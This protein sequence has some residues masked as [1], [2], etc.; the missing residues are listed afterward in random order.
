MDLVKAASRLQA[1]GK[2]KPLHLLF[3]GSGELGEKLRQ[4][5]SVVYDAEANQMSTN[6]NRPA[7]NGKPAASFAGFLNQTEISRAYVAADCLI[8]PS[9]ARETW[10][11]VVNEAMAS[12]LPCAVSNQCGCAQDLVAPINSELS[13]ALGDLN[14]M[15]TALLAVSRQVIEPARLKAQ[16]DKFDLAVSVDAVQRLYSQESEVVKARANEKGEMAERAGR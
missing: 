6:G 2:T 4:G 12:S 8:L 1:G 10:G 9:D 3:A 15:N 5:C 7:V 14:A 11:L 13:F 16:V